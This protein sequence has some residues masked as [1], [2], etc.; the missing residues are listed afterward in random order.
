MSQSENSE[1]KIRRGKVDSLDVYEVTKDELE[2][3]RQGSPNSIFLNFSIALFSIF[4]STGLTLFTLE[5][6]STKIFAVYICTLM[7]SFV[8]GLITLILWYR[9]ENNFN[10]CLKKIENRMTADLLI[11]ENSIETL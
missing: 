9:G 7:I 4:I 5:I 2:L 8:G 1:I 6:T 11:N 10:I 3:L